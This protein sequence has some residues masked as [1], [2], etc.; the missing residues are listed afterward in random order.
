MRD[1]EIGA[2][3]FT[4]RPRWSVEIGTRSLGQ[5]W[6]TTHIAATRMIARSAPSPS[7]PAPSARRYAA[8][9]L[10]RSAR[11]RKGYNHAANAY[12]TILASI[13]GSLVR[14]RPTGRVLVSSDYEP[15]EKRDHTR[16]DYP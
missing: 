15:K 8:L 16:Q 13:E 7:S 14:Q 9:G 12:Q 5:C 2:V 3:V 10:D 1:A 6:I 4:I 11:P